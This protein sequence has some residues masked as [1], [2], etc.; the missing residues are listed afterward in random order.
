MKIKKIWTKIKINWKNYL[1]F[2]SPFLITIPVISY[3]VI[4][5]NKNENIKI[6]NFKNPLS[7]PEIK[8]EKYNKFLK[9]NLNGELKIDDSFLVH[10][11][12][13]ILVKFSEHN[14]DLTYATKIESEKLAFIFFKW[15]YKNQINTKN[16][17]IELQ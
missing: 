12:K 9:K 7:F 5:S 8:I 2:F 13:D 6:I 16:F 10:I 1:I 3:F 11:I 15:D 14:L 4:T 17:K